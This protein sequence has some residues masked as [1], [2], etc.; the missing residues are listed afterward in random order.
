MF[1]NSPSVTKLA[2]TSKP[3]AEIP[4]IPH[5]NFS[6]VYAN[7]SHFTWF[8]SMNKYEEV[9]K[10]DCNTSNGMT[11]KRSRSINDKN[12][13]TFNSTEEDKPTESQVV[14]VKISNELIYVP[15]KNDIGHIIKLE[16][17]PG[18]ESYPATHMLDGIDTAVAKTGIVCNGPSLC[19]FDNRHLLTEKHCDDL[20][21]FV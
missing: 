1:F 17:V 11:R 12:S 7:H 16:V 21:N 18:N 3:M 2:L 13:T 9:K 4:V 5:L 19:I 6:M 15:T 20:M 14:W 8:K 10:M